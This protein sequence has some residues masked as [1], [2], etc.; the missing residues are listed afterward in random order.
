MKGAAQSQVGADG[1]PKRVKVGSFTHPLC[2]EVGVIHGPIQQ[3][4]PVAWRRLTVRAVGP[5]LSQNTGVITAQHRI[6]GVRSACLGIEGVAFRVIA[7]FDPIVEGVHFFK[8]RGASCRPVARFCRA[9][10][11]HD[12]VI[13]MKVST[14][15]GH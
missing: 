8:G 11:E 1:V 9:D 14:P 15:Q 12:P 3:H 5:E 13:R 4:K 10:V 2:G 6:W 7:S